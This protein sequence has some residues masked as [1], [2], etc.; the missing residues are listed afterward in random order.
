MKKRQVDEIDVWMGTFLQEVEYCCL[1]TVALI[2]NSR[3]SK[4][5]ETSLP[6]NKW[7]C[8]MLSY[9]KVRFLVKL[10]EMLMENKNPLKR[11]ITSK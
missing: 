6:K 3:P 2:T 9:G 1:L 11:P 10:F 4:F 8:D 7:S 5:L